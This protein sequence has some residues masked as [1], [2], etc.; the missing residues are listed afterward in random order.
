MLKLANGEVPV[1]SWEF[2]QSKGGGVKTTAKLELTNKRVV[3]TTESK[4]GTCREEIPVDKVK[5]VIY[6]NR[7]IEKQ[8]A[9]MMIVFGILT[10]WSLGIILLVYGIRLLT[11]S[12][13]EMSILSKGKEGTSLEIGV[14]KILGKTRKPRMKIK[15]REDATK[16]IVEAFGAALIEAKQM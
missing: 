16:D 4:R 3:Y 7:T 1:K 6:K 9:I 14:M 15:I 12:S 2:A 5:A 13:F 8:L 11:Q 10:I